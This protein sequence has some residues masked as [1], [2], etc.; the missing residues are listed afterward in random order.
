MRPIGTHFKSLPRQGER[1]HV[2]TRRN[3][4]IPLN[5]APLNKI[6]EIILNSPENERAN[7][8]RKTLNTLSIK[9]LKKLVNDTKQHLDNNPGE[10]KNRWMEIILDHF[11]TKMHHKNPLPEKKKGPQI[12]IPV[13]FENKGIDFIR[14]YLCL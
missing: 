11:Y 10:R 5:I 14:K 12:R 6:L 4:E 3:R 7:I 2:T 8:L 13:K 1:N 9:E